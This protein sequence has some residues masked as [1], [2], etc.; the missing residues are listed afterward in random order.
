MWGETL[1]LINGRE[2]EGEGDLT[3]KRAV[4]DCDKTAPPAVDVRHH[5]PRPTSPDRAWRWP[6]TGVRARSP[7]T[8]ITADV[9]VGTDAANAAGPTTTDGCSPFTNAAAVAGKWAY[10]DRGTCAFADKV[11]NAPD[12]RRRPASSSATT[13]PTSAGRRSPATQRS[14]A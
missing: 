7:P 3:A 10:V 6:P 13:T 4:G 12:R 8:A 14:T 2:D 5:S 11:D 1:D 9:V